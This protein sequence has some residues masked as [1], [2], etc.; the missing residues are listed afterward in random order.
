MAN[1]ERKIQGTNIEL[2]WGFANASTI[3]AMSITDLTVFVMGYFDLLEAFK[4]Q[5]PFLGDLSTKRQNAIIRINSS[6]QKEVAEIRSMFSELQAKVRERLE[7]VIKAVKKGGKGETEIVSSK[8]THKVIAKL[9]DDEFV[10]VFEPEKISAD[11]DLESEIKCLD[12]VIDA[13][14]V[15][16]GKKPSQLDKCEK[17]DCSNLFFKYTPSSKFCST[18]CS[19]AVQQAKFKRRTPK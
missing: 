14:L 15:G 7:T 4:A 8:V 13:I 16:Y 6:N 17:V 3:S 11:L 5:M 18:R 19:N 2:F 9:K 10:S 12:I 1:T